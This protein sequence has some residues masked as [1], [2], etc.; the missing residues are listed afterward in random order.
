V[1]DVVTYP[2][3]DRP[4]LV[5]GMPPYPFLV[6]VAGL[7]LLLFVTGFHWLALAAAV[8]GLPIGSLLLR[9]IGRRDPLRPRLI[10][11]YL[12]GERFYRPLPHLAAPP[13]RIGRRALL[14]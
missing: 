3:L 4:V 13:P 14:P 11:Q 2:S 10:V 12:M 1:H 7:A 6:L 8:A 5:M 9:L